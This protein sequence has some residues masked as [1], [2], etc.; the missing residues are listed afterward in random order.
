[1]RRIHF[2]TT[3][4]FLFSLVPTCFALEPSAV[5]LDAINVRHP[6]NNIITAGQPTVND[7]KA[8]KAAG[9]TA[10]INLRP[11]TERVNFDE[12]ATVE[13][14][15]MQYINIPVSGAK[16]LTK[17]NAKA[18]DEI[19]GKTQGTSFVHCGSG[20]RAGGLFAMRAF[21]FQDKSIDESLQVGENFGLTS[22]APVVKVNL[23]KS[24]V[25]TKPISPAAD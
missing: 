16:G 3:A 4:V 21:Y 7:I 24:Q 18:L 22:L 25:H 15:G 13:A 10:V 14:L 6:A 17:D 20:N 19:L 11:K 23:L 1:M 9:V 2:L 5:H 8:L 12:K